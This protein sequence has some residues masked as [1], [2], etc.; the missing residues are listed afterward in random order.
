MTTSTSD[1]AATGRSATA[2]TTTDTGHV[3]PE[4]PSTGGA[5]LADA[6]SMNVLLSSGT[7]L[8]SPERRTGTCAGGSVSRGAT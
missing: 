5:L 3:A 2:T 4:L 8:T 1:P 6:L 7:G